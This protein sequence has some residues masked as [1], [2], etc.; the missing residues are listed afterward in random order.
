MAI[1][2]QQGETRVYARITADS[3]AGAV[4]GNNLTLV[5]DEVSVNGIE[6]ADADIAGALATQVNNVKTALKALFIAAE[7]IAAS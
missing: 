3:T 2:K 6:L 4:L 5:I 1:S 7:G